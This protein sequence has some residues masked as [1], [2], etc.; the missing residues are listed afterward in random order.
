MNDLSKKAHLIASLMAIVLSCVCLY[1]VTGLTAPSVNVERAIV[2]QILTRLDERER[3]IADLNSAG[4]SEKE[5]GIVEIYLSKIRKDGVASHLEEKRKID[6]LDRNTM[7]LNALIDAYLPSAR[8]DG[9]RED[10]QTFR[11]YASTWA[12]RWNSVFEYFMVGGDYPPYHGAFPSKILG[13][14]KTELALI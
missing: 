2:Q 1:K 8:T 11:A 5:K 6:A 12:S 9:F 10:A 7:A 3:L 4:L 13:S 14:V